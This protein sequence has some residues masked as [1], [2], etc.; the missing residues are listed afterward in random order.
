MDLTIAAMQ[1]D[2]LAILKSGYEAV[3]E[4]IIPFMFKMEEQ[5]I[6]KRII[7]L[8]NPVTWMIWHVLRVE[9]MFL[10]DVVFRKE[11]VYHKDKWKDQLN[12]ETAQVGTG[13]TKE[14]ADQLSL[15][16]DLIQL[17]EYNGAVKEHTMELLELLPGWPSDKLDD[18]HEIEKRLLAVD[19]FPVPV[20]RERAVAYAPTPVSSCILGVISHTYMHF[21][22]YLAVTKPW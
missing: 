14:H 4:R 15:Q 17:K 20:A 2:E 18:A 8:I 7:P 16:I 3:H 21:G 10:S 6:R 19:A 5:K 12:I 1:V 9:D 22:Q 11:Q 13:M